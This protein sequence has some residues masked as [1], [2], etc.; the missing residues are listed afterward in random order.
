RWTS[1]PA[2]RP[3]NSSKPMTA[4]PIVDL[5]AP[6]SPTTPRISPRS[7]DSVT[8]STAT[9]LPRR[10]ANSM[11]I[12]SMSSNAMARPS[13]QLGVERVAQPVA[14]QVHRQHQR[15]QGDARENRNPPH[16]REQVAV[17][18]ADQRAQ[19][20]RGGRHAH[21]QEGQ[22]GFGDDGNGQ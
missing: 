16:A 11:R 1:P 6:D 13:A 19:R 10:L 3:G 15:D 5:P 9:R 2:R 20:R 8:P 7:S 14:Q 22:R 17:A 4:L 12:F 18:D 21:A